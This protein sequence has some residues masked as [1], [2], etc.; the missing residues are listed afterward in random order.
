MVK[1]IRKLSL[2]Q[3]IMIGIVIGTTLGFL[4]PEWTFISVLGELFV[5]ALKAIA[6][7]LVFV[8]IIASL[9]Q[10]KAGAKTYVGSILV[11]YLLAT[12]LAAVVA[13]TA[14][15]L[16]PVKIV[17]EAAQE[18]QAAPTQLSDVLSNVL[19]SVV[20]NPIQAMIEGNYLSVLFWSSLI[21]IGLRQSSVATKDVIANLSTGITTVVQMIIGIAPIGI[22]GLVF[23]SVATTGIAGLAKYGQLLL[24]LIGTMAVVA[25]VVYPAIVFWNIRQNPYPLVF[26]VL[27]ESA[28]PAFFTRSSAANIPINMELAK[29]MDLNE[30]SYAVSIPLGAT[31]NMGGAAITITIMTL[32]AV[33]TL[34]MSVPIYLALLLSII[35]AVS[36][37]GASGI[38]GGSLL[39]IPLAC[40]LFGISNDIAMQVVGVGFIVGV[41]QDSIETALNSSS[42]LLFTTSVELADRRKNGEIIDVKALIGKSQ[43]VVEQENI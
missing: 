31:I 16:F 20:Q 27:K 21:G 33:H 12:F 1:A 43:L 14:S 29:A 10:Q 39:L 40:S 19:T 4:V 37:C 36:A 30:E 17:L 38:A 15:Y 11:V 2:I 6:P 22:L 42:D 24:L 28:I 23:H 9:S 13:V 32:A 18:S 41:V 26:F 3:K 7:I 34:G 5:G 8:L 35:A 25:L